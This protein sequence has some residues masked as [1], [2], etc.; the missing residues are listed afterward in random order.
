MQQISSPVR[1][2]L[3]TGF[4]LSLIFY[5]KASRQR[6]PM[7]VFLVLGAAIMVLL[8]RVAPLARVWMY[9]EAFYLIFAAG[10]LVWLAEVLLHKNL[11]Q[12]YTARLLPTVILLSV[13]FMF[14]RITLNTQNGSL[15]PNRGD[16]PEQHAAEY[17]AS[18]MQADDTLLAISPVDIQTAYYLF[19]YGIPYEVFYQRDHPV[20]VQKATVILRVNSKYKTPES[21]LG[22]YNL[23]ENFDPASARQVYEYG[24]IRVFVLSAK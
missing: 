7:P 18:H 22:Y 19:M 24:P 3:L 17:L 2:L 13:V 23:A 11:K 21:V 4:L 8:Q 10:G 9:L 20:E 16:F 1:Y 14:V 15:V 5:R 6:L 12:E